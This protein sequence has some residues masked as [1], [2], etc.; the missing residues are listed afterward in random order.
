MEVFILLSKESTVHP[1][2]SPTVPNI[3]YALIELVI[4]CGDGLLIDKSLTTSNSFGYT[5]KNQPLLGI[6]SMAIRRIGKFFDYELTIDITRK[7][8]FGE[9][10]G[11]YL[12]KAN[13]R[14]YGV[15]TATRTRYSFDIRTGIAV[16]NQLYS[17]EVLERQR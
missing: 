1:R 6:K 14:A 2:L 4:S 13:I 17:T 11:I 5:F 10:F 7:Q 9:N 8:N 3:T 16:L 12:A 15:V